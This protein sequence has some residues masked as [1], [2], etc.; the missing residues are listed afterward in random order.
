MEKSGNLCIHFNGTNIS[1]EIHFL[2]SKKD[3]IQRVKLL[4]FEVKIKRME[5]FDILSL[6]SGQTSKIK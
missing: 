1:S 4:W 5:I 2:W 3:R 6:G